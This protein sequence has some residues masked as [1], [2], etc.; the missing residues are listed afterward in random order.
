MRL[1]L[2]RRPMRRCGRASRPAR[3]APSR[4]GRA[5][6]ID[7]WLTR[8]RPKVVVA[9]L[10]TRLAD[11]VRRQ[12]NFAPRAVRAGEEHRTGA[13]RGLIPGVAEV[14]TPR[15]AEVHEKLASTHR[16]RMDASQ[17]S[18][19]R[20][21]PADCGIGEDPGNGSRRIDNAENRTPPRARK[22][23]QRHHRRDPRESGSNSKSE[24]LSAAALA[25]TVGGTAWMI[26]HPVPAP[27]PCVRADASPA[28]TSATPGRSRPCAAPSWRA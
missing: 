26:T 11:W 23:G 19:A 17:K 6:A 15:L 4:A 9:R 12:A 24:F 16:H 28:S 1:L 25:I 21:C 22:C 2:G 18:R 3:N 20:T 7:R 8:L 14:H 5:R 10:P 27:P 13:V